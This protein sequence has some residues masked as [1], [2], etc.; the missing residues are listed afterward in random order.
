MKQVFLALSLMLALLA[1][2]ASA[3]I[4]DWSD[5]FSDL[6]D[7]TNGVT[8]EF[9]GQ[10]TGSE[11][12]GVRITAFGD[13]EVTGIIFDFSVNPTSHSIVYAWDQAANSG[14]Q[15]VSITFAEGYLGANDGIRGPTLT[16]TF[17][18][19]LTSSSGSAEFTADF[20]LVSGDF[21]GNYVNG[22]GVP[23]RGG[24]DLMGITL[25]TNQGPLASTTI[26]FDVEAAGI[27]A[28]VV[29][30]P[31]TIGFLILLGCGFVAR[32]RRRR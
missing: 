11:L 4:V 31:S 14:G 10:A 20:D 2:T 25:L 26:N 32:R 7:P 28:S 29:P 3:D 27:A 5:R 30:E 12:D 24:F 17:D 18:T 23:E 19:A 22:L 1:S 9:Q 13:L 21:L 6:N 8:L 15:P 16:A